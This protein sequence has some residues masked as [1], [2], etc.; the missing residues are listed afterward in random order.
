MLLCLLNS[1]GSLVPQGKHFTSFNVFKTARKKTPETFDLRGK[2]V[3]ITVSQV[4]EPG[5]VVQSTMFTTTNFPGTEP[6]ARKTKATP[7]APP[8]SKDAGKPPT[9]GVK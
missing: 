9:K 7:P 5:E 2:Y 8:A 6:R 4:S 1:D 3:L